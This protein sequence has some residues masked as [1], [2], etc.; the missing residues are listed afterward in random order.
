M[1]L[2]WLTISG[3]KVLKS[4]MEWRTFQP[5]KNGDGMVVQRELINTYRNTGPEFS[6]IFNN[7]E[8]EE[9]GAFVLKVA[10][11]VYMPKLNELMKS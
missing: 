5:R 3:L 9:A 1:I 8:V 2:R 4:R 7:S 11:L 10:I 6:D